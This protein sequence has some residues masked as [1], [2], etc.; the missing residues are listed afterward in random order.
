MSKL[1]QDPH[2]NAQQQLSAVA[3]LLRTNYTNTEAFDQAIKAL[4]EPDRVLETKLEIT[5]DS[6]KKQQFQAYRSQHNNARGP[7]KG[8]IRFHQ[9]VTL[10]EV[11]ALSTWM[12]WKCAVTGTPYGG[13]KGGIVVDPRTLSQNELERLSRAYARF[14]ADSIGAWVDVPAPDVNTNGQIMAWMV[15]E[16]QKIQ[17]EKYPVRVGAQTNPLATFTGKPLE[18]GGSEGREEA[19]GLAG[20]F[21]LEKLVEKL[22]FTRKQDVTVAI[23]GFGNVGY[24]FA[25]HADRLGYKV[26]AV[27]DSKGG[28]YV[29]SGLDPAQTL[30]CKRDQGS[31]GICRCTHDSCSTLHGKAITNQE[32]LELP[33]TV[34]VPAALEN[35]I[36]ADNADKIQATAV[37]EMA[38]GPVT[39]EADQILAQR[40]I[41]LVPDVLA[42][43]GGVTT[44]YFEWVQNL[45]GYA[46]TKEEVISKLKPLMEQSF[47]AMWEQKERH[48]VDG[49]TATYLSA[50]KRVIDAMLLRG[51]QK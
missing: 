2:K 11:K 22:G 26:V 29:E 32:L 37:L 14:I 34:L 44:S 41:I 51:T 10:S 12:T 31:V 7:Y 4:L 24:W 23:Q 43:A 21:V 20:V 1:T 5:L 42:N 38:N 16:Y 6:G 50:V 15:D 30:Q 45:Q 49:R 46:W 19:T 35:V 25:Y 39:P 27:S 8:G 3:K 33:V 47:A 13:G 28:V 9:G 17:A 48:G 36:T 40:K 18:L